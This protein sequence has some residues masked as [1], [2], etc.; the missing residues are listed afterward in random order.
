MTRLHIGCH[1]HN[2]Q[3][4]INMDSKMELL[5][6]EQLAEREAK[7]K[8]LCSNLSDR[9]TNRCKCG[10]AAKLKL[11]MDAAESKRI[12]KELGL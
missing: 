1:Y 12:N 9:L 2:H 6:A 8:A 3:K 10:N 4:A 5:K 11:S 7:K